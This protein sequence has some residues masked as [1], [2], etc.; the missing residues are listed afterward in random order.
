MKKLALAFAAAAVTLAV[1]VPAS[2]EE[3]KLRVG[4]GGDHHRMVHRAPVRHV[5]VVRHDRGLHRGFVHS[6]HYGYGKAKVVKL[7]IKHHGK[8]G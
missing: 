5:T 4:V 2:A 8:H 3:V 6:R 1:A 7:K